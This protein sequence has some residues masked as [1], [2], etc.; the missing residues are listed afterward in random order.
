MTTEILVTIT[1]SYDL[2]EFCPDEV[3]NAVRAL[4]EKANESG[5]VESISLSTDGSLDVEL[6]I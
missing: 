2:G 3:V 1:V 6:N 4:Q 5:A